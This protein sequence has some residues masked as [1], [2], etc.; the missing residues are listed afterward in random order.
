MQLDNSFFTKKPLTTK[1]KI[2]FPV[3][4]RELLFFVRATDRTIADLTIGAG[5]H[6]LELL[7]KN[8][9]LFLYGIDQDSQILKICSQN[10]IDYKNRIIL[11]QNNFYS[12][13][14]E[15]QKQNKK[16]NFILAD[17]GVSSL[18]LETAERGFSFNKDAKLDMRM[19][20]Q[21]ELNASEI[22]N[23]YPLKKLEQ[24]FFE[25]GEERHWKILAKNI[26]LKRRQQKIQTTLQLSNL[27]SDTIPRKPNQKIHPATK[28]FQ[29]I[30]IEVNKELQSLKKMLPI[31]LELLKPTGRLLI[32]S[33]HSLEDRIVKQQFNYWANP[34]TTTPY[35]LAAKK[36]DPLVKLLSKKPITP[37][38]DEI[39]FNHRSRSAK[40]R[41]IE[42]I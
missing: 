40:L 38:E 13:L 16:F 37:H 31:A 24:I 9:N 30:R 14:E 28:V 39:K 2:H 17:L 25:Y 36:I 15:W 11:L 6:S 18:Q 19:N 12:Q 22:I 35:P 33:F 20:Q 4:K 34:P 41:I 29:A 21:Q 23:N 1:S 5:G 42:K 10:L 32:I 7:K 3:L 26:F 8:K 27:I